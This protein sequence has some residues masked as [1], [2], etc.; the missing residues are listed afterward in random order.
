[1]APSVKG[2]ALSVGGDS[3]SVEVPA[4]LIPEGCE[5]I[6]PGMLPLVELT[7]KEIGRIVSRV[8]GGAENVQDIYPLGPLQEGILFHHLMGGE[9]DAYLMSMQ[10]SL[11][12]RARVDSYLSALHWVIERHDILRT[13]MYWEGLREPVQVVQR[14][15]RLRVEEVELDAEGGDV[16]EQL[17][18]RFDPRHSRMDVSEAPL[19]R[20]FVTEDGERGRWMLLLQFHHLVGD[21]MTLEVIQEEIQLYLR[22]ESELLPKA[23]PFRNFVAQAR[24]GVSREEHERF[25]T[26]ML[27]DVGEATAP[28]GLLEVQQDGSGIGEATVGL[29]VALSRRLRATARRLGVSAAS[30]C[31]VAWAQVLGKLSGREDVVFGTVLFGRMQGVAGSDRMVGSLINTL[32]VRIRVDQSSVEAGVRET[33]AVLAELLRHEHAPLALAQRCSQVAA[34]SP[35]FTALLNYRHSA[36]GPQSP[37]QA[38]GWEGI[39]LLRAEERTNY[40]LMLSVDDLGEGFGLTAQAV[41]SIDPQRICAYMCTAL[42]GLVEALERAPSTAMCTLEILTAEERIQLLYGWNDTA[43]PVAESTLPELFEAQVIKTPE[44]TAVVYEEQSLTYAE[45]NRLANQLAH[46]LRERGVGPEVIVGIC[47]ERSLEMVVGLLGILKA[48]GAYLP[49]DPSHPGERLGFMLEDAQP[50][51]VITAGAAAEVLPSSLS[52]LQLDQDETVAALVAQLQTNPK[53]SGLLPEHSAYVLYTSGSTGKPKG[54]VMPHGNLANLIRWQVDR[55]EFC[56]LRRVVQFA[57][58]GFDVAFQETFSTLCSGGSL[59]LIHEEMRHDPAELME[60]IWEKRI[61]RL[62][63]PYVALQSLAEVVSDSGGKF[64]GADEGSPLKE[65]ITAGEQLRVEGG[66]A[67]FFNQ[68]GDCS[69]KNQYGPTES[70]VVS[71]FELLGKIAVWPALPPIGRPIWNTQIYVLDG[72]LRP[73][74]VGVSGELYI[75]GAGLARG[76]LNRPELTSERFIA[77]PYGEPG[78]R[79]YRSGDVARYRADGNLEYLRRVDDQ[80]KIRGFR[81]ELGEIEAALSGHT[82]VAQSVVVAREDAPG[83]KRLVAYVVAASGSSI[84][85]A[86]LRSYLGRSLPEYMVPSAYVVLESLPLSPNGKLDRKQLPAPEWKSREYEAPVGETETQIAEVFADVLKLEHVGRED[87]FFE[88]GGHSLLATQVVSQL[89]QR[90]LE[91]GIRA[92]FMA[93]SVKGLAAAKKRIKEIAL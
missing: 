10:L 80:V 52:L 87:N 21:H 3:R 22:G 76:Y 71:S 25:F 88:L 39:E 28:F 9:G 90:G 77:S 79:M 62:F 84:D 60:F 48:G 82:S 37:E 59:F 50:L 44:A 34:G 53:R 30:V 75:A 58:L 19:L 51:C 35:L 17:Y 91:V 27:G 63:L 54:V 72:H 45:L 33:H 93:P 86:E 24:L 26:A 89:R 23:L 38:R 29:D 43:V 40:P 81:I 74:P 69:L 65:I 85:A 5:A 7:E 92:L 73:V 67:R 8:A 55:S 11:D 15:A 31:H 14:E 70:H 49:L 20:A 61:E 56:S 41:A 13:G 4:N 64:E 66:V 6:T 68:L 46:L 12:S 16:A 42:E 32:P 83:D 18:A 36:A 2:L 78:S 57:A 47:V 1:M